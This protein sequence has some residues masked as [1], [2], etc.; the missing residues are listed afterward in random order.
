MQT[1]NQKSEPQQQEADNMLQTASTKA[2]E[3]FKTQLMIYNGIEPG[4]N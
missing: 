2:G 1:D 3:E 4:L